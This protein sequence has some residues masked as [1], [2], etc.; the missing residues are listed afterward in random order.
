[1]SIIK[2]GAISENI[3]ITAITYICNKC[4]NSLAVEEN[5]EKNNKCNKCVDGIM[6][7]SHALPEIK[8]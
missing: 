6:I 1:M 3:T 7:L 2:K 5:K 4:G 8:Q